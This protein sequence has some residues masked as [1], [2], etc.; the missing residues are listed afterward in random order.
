[1]ELKQIAL[2]LCLL[3]SVFAPVPRCSPF[4]IINKL[5]EWTSATSD[6]NPY[7]PVPPCEHGGPLQAI[8]K[9]D[10]KSALL[11]AD[12][13]IIPRHNIHELI[14]FMKTGY[15]RMRRYLK[16]KEPIEYD[17]NILREGYDNHYTERIRTK[18]IGFGT[19][20]RP[21]LLDNRDVAVNF[22]GE[23]LKDYYLHGQDQV[24]TKFNSA[25]LLLLPE[26]EHLDPDLIP[27][28]KKTQSNILEILKKKKK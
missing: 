20:R 5:M 4:L 19:E 23:K 21:E 28:L 26:E 1:M 17:F 18:Q 9:G 7:F 25:G 11:M 24:A 12:P 22:A 14:W 15:A 13:D 10:Y 3:P 16:N 27:Q 6:M 2:L 8:L